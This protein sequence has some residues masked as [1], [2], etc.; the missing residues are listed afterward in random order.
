MSAGGQPSMQGYVTD[1]WLLA[2]WS[3]LSGPRLWGERAA[4]SDSV[5]SSHDFNLIGD[6]RWRV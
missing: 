4:N 2:P 6:E 1:K 5:A 3:A